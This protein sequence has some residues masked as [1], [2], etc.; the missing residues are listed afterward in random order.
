MT[1]EIADIIEKASRDLRQEELTH[2][3]L[4]AVRFISSAS[5]VHGARLF[6]WQGGLY[7]AIRPRSAG[8]FERLLNEGI[9][10]SLA[11]KGLLIKS[12]VVP[13]RLDGYGT[14]LKHPRIPFLTYPFE[15][16][17][18][19]LKEA[20]LRYIRLNLELLNYGLI[21]I[22]S[23]PWN[24]VF[25]GAHPIFVDLGSI[26]P[27]AEVD[28]RGSI[29][30]FKGYFIYPL[31]L[32][33]RGQ[34]RAARCL[35]S[36]LSSSITEREAV[37]LGDWRAK[38]DFVGKLFRMGRRLRRSYYKRTGRKNATPAEFAALWREAGREVAAIDLKPRA[39]QWSDYYKE[40]SPIDQPTSPKEQAMTAILSRLKPR[41]VLDLGCNTGWYSQLAAH[42]GARVI[43]CDADEM[44]VDRLYLE[45]KGKKAAITTAHLN[46]RTPSPSYGWSGTLFPS[47]MQRLKAECVL[48]LALVHHL[49]FSL[50]ADFEIVV[51]ALCR[52]TSRSLVVEFIGRNDEHVSKWWTES[53]DWYTLENFLSLLRHRFEKVGVVPS[54]CEAR[55]LIVCE[56]IYP[57]HQQ[58]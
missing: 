23:H 34:A 17:R 57:S 11:A 52:F 22:D 44:C 15:W 36:D 24:F 28:P 18:S 32:M 58:Q 14:V 47:A 2:V 49:V 13:L 48:A 4:N 43:A 37:A 39:S 16:P 50:L 8:L 40:P 38:F 42:L 55:V 53:Y 19:A 20:A 56:D 41:T 3:P 1:L 10:D 35:L 46:V 29:R 30:E 45:V 7:R 26:V 51:D 12:E 33:A 6:E 31:R 9:L 21:L 5:P 25:D 54:S 27:L